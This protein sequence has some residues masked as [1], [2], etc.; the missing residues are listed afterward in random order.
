MQT[1]F[2]RLI[3]YLKLGRSMIQRIWVSYSYKILIFKSINELKSRSG[4]LTVSKRITMTF[5]VS[6]L[7]FLG[8]FRV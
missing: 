3:F 1:L 5:P 6:S 4:H 7:T 8:S 2:I